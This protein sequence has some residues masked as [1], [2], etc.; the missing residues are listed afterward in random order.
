MLVDTL[1]LYGCLW[2]KGDWFKQRFF[3]QGGRDSVEP[4]QASTVVRIGDLM[5]SFDVPASMNKYRDILE[6]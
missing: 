4:V 3:C 6:S 1:L 5:P 2:R